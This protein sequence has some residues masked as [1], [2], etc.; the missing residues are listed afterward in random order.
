M[1]TYPK[2]ERGRET[3]TEIEHTSICEIV[4]IKKSNIEKCSHT[5]QVTTFIK[6]KQLYFLSYIMSVLKETELIQ[7]IFHIF[8]YKSN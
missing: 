6:S 4:L 5:I 2:H 3:E 8:C 1:Y 7:I